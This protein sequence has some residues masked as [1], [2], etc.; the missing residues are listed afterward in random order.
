MAKIGL[1]NFRYSLL[2]EAADGTPSYNGPQTPGKAV[3]CNVEISN[4]SAM[5]YADDTLA[6]SDTS[7]QSG[8][9]TMGIDEDDL[10]TMATLLGHTIS[11]DGIL[12]RN[13]ND[14]APYVGL[15]RVVV[16]MVNGVYKYK[17]EFLYKVKF[18]EPSAENNTKGESLEFATTEIEGTVAALANGN[19]SVAKTFESKADALSYLEELMAP[20]TANV[21]LTYNVNGGEGTIAPVSVA[22]RTA[23]TLNDGSTLTAPEGKEFSGWATTD[24]AETPNATSPY[25]VTENTTLYAVW[26]N[27]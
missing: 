8:T 23:V 9:V 17:V 22:A 16:K 18:S 2:T 24:S 26:T 4:N 6:E 25:T 7:F 27:A 14:A 11:E 3:S 21:T 1:N 5:L 13:A 15:G 12:T 20:P 19:W 10:E